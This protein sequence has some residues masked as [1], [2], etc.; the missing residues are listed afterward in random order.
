MAPGQQIAFEPALA[1]VLGKNLHHPAARR[2]VFV[3][4]QAL[5]VP[6]ALGHLEHMPEPVGERLVGAEQPEV[7]ALARS[8]P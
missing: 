7:A 1:G 2:E 6:G 5:G 4:G 3:I 8:P